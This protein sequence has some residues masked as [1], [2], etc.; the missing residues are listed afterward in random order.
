MV[1]LAFLAVILYFSLLYLAAGVYNPFIYFRFVTIQ[2][3]R[4]PV[5]PP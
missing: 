1:R 5:L 3:P 4:K 2:H